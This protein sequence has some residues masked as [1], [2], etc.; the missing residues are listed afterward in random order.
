M[1]QLPAPARPLHHSAE[2]AAGAEARR[3]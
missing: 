1:N 3:A 2:E